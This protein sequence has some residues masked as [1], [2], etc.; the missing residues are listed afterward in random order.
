MIDW[1]SREEAA[2]KAP[3]VRCLTAITS[4]VFSAA[5]LP[6]GLLA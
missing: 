5:S 1:R 2:E 6:E 4:R 3:E